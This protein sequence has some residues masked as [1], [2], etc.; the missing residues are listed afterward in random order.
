MR[1]LVPLL[2]VVLGVLVA[3]AIV[4]RG[5]A[6]NSNTPSAST[7]SPSTVAAVDGS[8]GG[9]AEVVVSGAQTVSGDNASALPSAQLDEAQP[10]QTD[11]ANAPAAAALPGFAKLVAVAET[12]PQGPTLGSDDPASAFNMKVSFTAFGAGVRQVTLADFAKT[13]ETPERYVLLDAGANPQFYAFAARS[14]TLNGT[15]LQLAALPWSSGPVTRSATGESLVYQLKINDDAGRPVA[16]IERAFELPADSYDL[17]LRQTIHNLTDAP[18]DA[19]FEQNAQGDVI[20]DDAAYLGDQRRFVTG[21]FRNEV[22]PK[23]AIYVEGAFLRRYQFVKDNPPVV[24]PN[25]YLDAAIQPRLAWLASENRYFAVVTHTLPDDTTTLKTADIVELE[26]VFPNVSGRLSKVGTQT[27]VMFSLGTGQTRI[28]PGSAA[29]FDLAVYAG[30]REKELF[31]QTPYAQLGFL[32]LVR[33]ELGCTWCT[34][35][36]LAHLL[37]GYLEVLHDY[38]VFDWGMAIILLVITVRLLLHPIT[39]KSQANMMRMGK[40]MGALQPEMQKLKEKY[41]DDPARMNKEVMQLYREKNI[42]PANMLG[43]LPMFLQ[44]PIWVALYAMLYFAIELRHQPAFY[45]V[46]QS[47]SGG[48]WHFLQ[49]L[50]VADHFIKF[51]GNGYT[52]NLYFVQPHF[53]GINVLPLLMAVVFY[54]NMKFTTPPA[55]TEEQRQQ[56]KIMKIM[57]FIFPIFLYSAPSGLTLYITVST[58]AGIVDSWLVRKHVREQE[59][60]GELFK[61]KEPPKPGSLRWKLQQRFDMARQMA[62][63]RME[64]QQKKSQADKTYKQRKK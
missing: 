29:R 52:L 54:F 5:P 19:R 11:T 31:K 37:L 15:T 50:S 42:N 28:A 4:N 51:P 56:Q 34:F 41:K 59:E 63:Q 32:D 8:E 64:D 3:L 13:I 45:G 38:V 35:Q 25:P 21:Y 44:M 46:F 24:W 16:L 58:L 57:P 27:D 14:I 33:Y 36:W 1:I 18:L 23:T 9:D 10:P 17:R 20:N 60:R 7:A 53:D 6:G 62:E 22:P 26:T 61:K 47:I 30:P 49:D 2:A 48:A 40:Q 55:Q 39:K 43:C 12:S